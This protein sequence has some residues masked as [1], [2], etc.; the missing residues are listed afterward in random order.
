MGCGR[1]WIPYDQKSNVLVFRFMNYSYRYSLFKSTCNF[2]LITREEHSSLRDFSFWRNNRSV[3]FHVFHKLFIG[4][5]KE[6]L[7][8]TLPAVI[9]LY[10]I[11]FK[12][13]GFFQWDEN[14][15][16][17]FCYNETLFLSMVILNLFKS[18]SCSE[19]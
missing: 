16:F 6:V 7:C 19:I 15:F 5:A 13:W 12:L 10:N 8:N 11:L 14:V 17:F 2:Y 3:C 4:V 9:R 1:K 18:S